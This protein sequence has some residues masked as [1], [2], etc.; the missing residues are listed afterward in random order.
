VGIAGAAVWLGLRP[1]AEPPAASRYIVVETDPAAATTPP[2]LDASQRDT[3]TALA[4]SPSPASGTPER[5][6]TGV[7]VSS[8]PGSERDAL[9]RTFNAQGGAIRACFAQHIDPATDAPRLEVHFRIDADGA[10]DTA[11][12]SPSG[13]S[14]TPLGRCVLGIARAM[15]FG[16]RPAPLGFSIPVTVARGSH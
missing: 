14:N 2:D 8:S 16:A 12:I 3:G 13:A 4:A 1:P 15:R 11:S 9:T 6:S 7:A 5:T 10:V